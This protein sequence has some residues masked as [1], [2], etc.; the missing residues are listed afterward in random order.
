M[1]VFLNLSVSISETLYAS[2][3]TFSVGLRP[4][5]TTSPRDFSSTAILMAIVSD[6]FKSTVPLCFL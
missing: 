2:R 5:T 3:A 4:S 1:V 6:D